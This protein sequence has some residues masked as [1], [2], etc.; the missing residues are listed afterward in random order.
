[1]TNIETGGPAFP[2]LNIEPDGN[3]G[4]VK[5]TERGMSLH[6][7]F[8]IAALPAVIHT[9]CNDTPRAGQTKEEYFAEKTIDV[10]NAMLQARK[11]NQ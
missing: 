1:M 2:E 5:W 9:C 7:A 6:D 4:Y 8:M 3:G 10:A 11:G